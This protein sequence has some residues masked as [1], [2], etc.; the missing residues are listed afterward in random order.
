MI[1]IVDDEVNTRIG[2]VKLLCQDGYQTDAVA[3]G[4]EALEYLEKKM[5]DLVITDINMPEMNG[6]VFFH[7]LTQYYPDIK[8]IMI[9][10][11]SGVER[12]LHLT[13]SEYPT[14]LHKPF[15]VEELRALIRNSLQQPYSLKGT[16]AP[17]RR[18][19]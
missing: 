13:D 4:I 16:I 11:Y 9:T 8:V 3:N 17:D 2:L 12:F 10:A 1:L 5:V 19:P 18:R 14:C 6:F 15:K 7:Q